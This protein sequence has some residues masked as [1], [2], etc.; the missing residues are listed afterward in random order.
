M[1][2]GASVSASKTSLYMHAGN[3]DNE[4][5]IND[6]KK[7]SGGKKIYT[8]FTKALAAVIVSVTA[9][10]A[11][12][13]TA[14]VD[15]DKKIEYYN[16]GTYLLMGRYPRSEADEVVSAILEKNFNDGTLAKNG[17]KYVYENNRYARVV[18][19][20]DYVGTDSDD[21]SFFLY[22]QYEIGS[23]HWFL[24][25]DIKWR[26]MA[27]QNKY[28][29]LMTDELIATK[30][31]SDEEVEKGWLWENS[32]LRAWLN[33]EFF[34]EAFDEKER[35][36]IAT[37]ETYCDYISNPGRI[38][39]PR[40]TVKDKVRVPRWREIREPQLFR[41]DDDRM[42]T[43]TDY[44]TA[45]GGVRLSQAAI[46]YFVNNGIETVKTPEECKKYIGC[47]VYWLADTE[48]NTNHVYIVYEYG[49]TMSYYATERSRTVRPVILCKYENIK[50][51][52]KK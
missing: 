39:Y 41:N 10:F 51:E 26:L 32:N 14:K 20:N 42:A 4:I 40:E 52:L 30:A 1:R 43:V 17:D 16:D 45:T 21:E 3:N 13:C 18:V 12:A 47:G 48:L 50:N 15:F 7:T 27:V 22:T 2:K 31:F 29:M 8:I 44:A 46:D 9:C 33:D 5:R 37:G 19:K 6:L 49:N 25:E 38:R 34:Y 28:A 36:T 35:K 11:A 23:V 24:V